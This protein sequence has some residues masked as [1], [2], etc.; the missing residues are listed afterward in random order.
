[1][2]DLDNKIV[3]K[4]DGKKDIEGTIN[5]RF[6]DKDEIIRKGF[7]CKKLFFWNL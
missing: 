1:M 7:F 3:D 6:K 5:I 2:L 4:F